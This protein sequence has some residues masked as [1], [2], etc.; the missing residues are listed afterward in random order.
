VESLAIAATDQPLEFA[1]NGIVGH[2]RGAEYNSDRALLTLQSAVDATL[3][4]RGKPVTLTASHAVLDHNAG[5]SRLTQVNTHSD[6]QTG[7]ADNV[8]VYSRKDGSIDH[9][10]ASGAVTLSSEDYGDIAAPIMQLWMDLKSQPARA[11]ASGGIHYNDKEDLLQRT[12]E[13][14]DGDAIFANKGQLRLVHLNGNVKMHERSETAAPAGKAAP[15]ALER[16]LSAARLTLGFAPGNK[17]PGNG[18]QSRKTKSELQTVHAE[19][20]AHFSMQQPAAL[21]AM[22][23]PPSGNKPAAAGDLATQEIS[24]DVLDGTL[25]DSGAKKYFSHIQGNGHTHLV[26]TASDGSVDTS[27]GDSINIVMRPQP[28]P[29]TA[30]QPAA[31]KPQ[32]PGHQQSQ[33]TQMEI[34]SAVQTG[35]VSLSQTTPPAAPQAGKPAAKPAAPSVTTGNADRA[36]YTGANQHLVLTGNPEVADS[37]TTIWAQ[38]ITLDQQS[39]NL[40]AEGTVKANYLQAENAEPMH[41]IADHAQM[42]HAQQRA[43]FYGNAVADARLWQQ[44]SQVSAPVLDILRSSQTL[45]AHGEGNAQMPVHAVFPADSMKPRGTNPVSANPGSAKPSPA[46]GAAG[47]ARV[48]S[49]QMVYSGLAH[50]AIFTGGVDVVSADSRTRSRQATVWLQDSQTKSAKT[51]P[52]PAPAEA[53]MLSGNVERIQAEG[54]VVIEQPGRRGYGESLLYTTQDGHY[55]LTGTP[56][57]PPKLIDD[58]KGTVTGASLLFESNDDTVIV[59]GGTGYNRPRVDTHAK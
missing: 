35:H 53:P 59:S 19:G 31:H 21:S 39:G 41:I 36:E 14:A 22:A 54:A 23:K 7:H 8:T 29:V 43:I 48:A 55:L 58:V 37:G 38:R 27:S 3:K 12:G 1:F 2:A 20:A 10:D 15:P 18:R 28:A 6:A 52:Q 30:H 47:V 33:P 16:N 44:A 32:Q 56:A 13:A 49:H 46:S 25:S 24:G 51:A 4:L 40:L 50:T 5:E 9:I 26:Q 45:T 17:V 57:A 42:L 11:S 34:V